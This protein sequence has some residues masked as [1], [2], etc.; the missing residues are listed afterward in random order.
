M[1]QGVSK[2]RLTLNISLVEKCYLLFSL[3]TRP[4]NCKR[5][6]NKNTYFAKRKVP[7]KGNISSKIFSNYSKIPSKFTS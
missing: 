6:K 4:N 1:H 3:Y 5:G 7:S 2:V